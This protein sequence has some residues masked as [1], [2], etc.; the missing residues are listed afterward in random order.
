MPNTNNKTNL[1]LKTNIDPPLG[2]FFSLRHGFF[3]PFKKIMKDAL[4]PKRNE[5]AQQGRDNDPDL[6]DNSAIQPGAGTISSSETDQANESPSRT[7]GQDP[8]SSDDAKED[9][10]FDDVDF[11]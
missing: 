7:G 10:T 4:D 6:R 5:P 2:G 11:D 1:I 3:Y 9:R 8:R